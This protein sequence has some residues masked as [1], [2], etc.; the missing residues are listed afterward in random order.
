MLPPEV[1]DNVFSFL[2]F[3]TTA[4]RSCTIAFPEFARVIERHLY[5]HI[6]VYNIIPEA[7]YAEPGY[8][9]PQLLELLSDNPRVANYARSLK[10]EMI[11]DSA[12]RE[13]YPEAQISTILPQLHSL[14]NIT[15]STRR[16]H[17]CLHEKFR[18]AFLQCLRSSSTRDVTIRIAPHKTFPLSAFD[19]S[20]ALK[21][22]TVNGSFEPDLTAHSPFPVLESL[23]IEDHDSLLGVAVWEKARNLRSLKVGV[24]THESFKYVKRILDGCKDSLNDLDLYVEGSCTSLAGFFPGQQ[25]YYSCR[26]HEIRHQQ[27]RIRETR[28]SNPLGPF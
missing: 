22:L 14:E 24:G 7:I 20:K 15:L 10:I 17:H 6:T 1:L 26:R 19:R 16:Y 23:V 28:I 27:K 18:D 25:P 4:L 21:R 8:D 12:S 9:P 13:L 2:C 11:A 5:F 3:D